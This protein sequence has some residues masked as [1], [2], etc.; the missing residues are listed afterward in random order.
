MV[1]NEKGYAYLYTIENYF[2]VAVSHKLLIDH[3]GIVYY[4]VKYAQLESNR[5]VLALCSLDYVLIVSLK[6]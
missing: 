3:S 4:D 1:I 2:W 5:Q 6:P